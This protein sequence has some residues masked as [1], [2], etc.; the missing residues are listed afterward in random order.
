MFE[1]FVEMVVLVFLFSFYFFGKI[2]LILSWKIVE[3]FIILKVD[4]FIAFNSNFK[5]F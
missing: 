4:L 3:L 2:V 1:D 5:Q